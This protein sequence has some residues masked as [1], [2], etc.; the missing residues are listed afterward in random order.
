MLVVSEILGEPV[1]I[2]V[3]PRDLLAGA[4]RLIMAAI[5]PA[6]DVI[7]FIP[8]AVQR[9]ALASVGMESVRFLSDT[10]IM[11]AKMADA[12]VVVLPVVI[13][14]VTIGLRGGKGRERHNPEGK[15]NDKDG[16]LHRVCK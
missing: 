1:Q 6:G 16:I 12:I 14:I 8:N 7:D 4:R 9:V 13:V 15:R 11:F 2:R 3:K 5:D 10:V